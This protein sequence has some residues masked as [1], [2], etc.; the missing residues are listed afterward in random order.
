METTERLVKLY[1]NN[2]KKSRL[3]RNKNKFQRIWDAEKQTYIKVRKT[4]YPVRSVSVKIQADEETLTKKIEAIKRRQSK[5]KTP[6]AKKATTVK[7]TTKP[8][9]HAK[10]PELKPA[11]TVKLYGKTFTW[12]NKT[13]Q[14]KAA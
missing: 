1:S 10:M 9:V 13:L 2:S 14:Y 7:M 12:D 3:K 4:K 6:K 11:T 8:V 5:T